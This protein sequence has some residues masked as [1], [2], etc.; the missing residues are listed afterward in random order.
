MGALFAMFGII[1]LAKS[2]R[3][4]IEGIPVSSL[5]L[6]LSYA[7]VAIPSAGLIIALWYAPYSYEQRWLFFVG[8]VLLLFTTSTIQK[9]VRDLEAFRKLNLTSPPH[10]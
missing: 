4:K 3:D 10:E 1:A 8:A 2:T 6:G 9:N 7:A 5:F